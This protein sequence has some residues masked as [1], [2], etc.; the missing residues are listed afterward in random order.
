MVHQHSNLLERRVAVLLDQTAVCLRNSPQ[1]RC[2][3]YQLAALFYDGPE[4]VARLAANPHIIQMLIEQCDYTLELAAGVLYVNPAAGFAGSSEAL[5]KDPGKQ[6]VR[7]QSAVVASGD[8]GV[9]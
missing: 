9:Q 5:A 6:C 8:D 1:V 3:D 4:P 7:S 2:V